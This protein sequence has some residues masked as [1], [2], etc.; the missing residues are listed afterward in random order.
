VTLDEPIRVWAPGTGTVE[1]LAADVRFPAIAEPD[2][3]WRGPALPPGTD[4]AICLDGGAPL[5]DPRSRWQPHGVHGAS[6]RL[7]LSPPS[8]FVPMPLRDALIYELH[9]GTFSAAGTFAGAAEHLDHLVELGITHVELMPIAQWSGGAGWGYDGVDLFAPHAPYGPPAELQRLIDR[10]HARGLAVIVD[11]VHN[12]FGPDGAYLHR[13]GPYTTDRHRTPWG[14]AVNLDGEH[15]REVRRFLIDSALAWLRDY[16]ADGLR[17]DAVHSLR[18]DGEPHFVAEL[19]DAIRSLERE[20][21]RPFVVIGEYDDHDPRA[22]TARPAGWGLDAHWNDD[23]HH[24]VHALLT[25]EATGY[26]RD[27]AERDTLARV[28]ARGYALDG[29]VSRHRGGPHGRPYGGLPRDRLVAYV[30]SHDQ[31]GNR[32]AGERLHVLAGDARARIAAAILFTAPFV[33]MIFQ[34]EEWAASTPF[35]YFADFEDP[36]LCTAVREGRR[37]EHAGAGWQTEPIDPIDPATHR[38]CVLA[39]HELAEPAHA[40]M[41]GWYRDLARARRQTP[42]LRDPDAGATRVRHRGGRLEIERGDCTLICN[43]DDAPLAYD[44]AGE[45]VL[46]SEPDATRSRLPPLSCVLLRT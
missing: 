28:L 34:G 13:F 5:P 39:W 16:G 36:A 8:A 25:G 45:I 20:L 24:A 21:R 29:R 38:A 46:A 33:P 11:V 44:A 6:R 26:Y 18:D 32:A 10:C 37:R 9:L 43:L 30:Q 23:F 1:I 14:N 19:V 7:A 2:G 12:H 31:I 4:Y 40:R 35:L 41:L 15:A 42:A 22:V 3:W 17:L 27:F